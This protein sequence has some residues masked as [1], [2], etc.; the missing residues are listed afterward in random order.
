MV[1]KINDSKR[2]IIDNILCND[3]IIN[4]LKYSNILE[5]AR[6]REVSKQ[7]LNL[8]NCDKEIIL[9]KFDISTYSKQINLNW[10]HNFLKSKKIKIVDLL[11]CDDFITSR[12]I[13]SCIN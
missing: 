12:D 11:L 13:L 1:D 9:T 8:I 5:I 6:L 2:K 4:I 10:L 3:I 7:F